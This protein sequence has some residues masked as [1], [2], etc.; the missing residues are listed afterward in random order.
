ML[1]HLCRVR[2]MSLVLDGITC[3]CC[4]KP[5]RNRGVCK[6]TYA[7]ARRMVRAGKVTWQELERR[8]VVLESR[9]GQHR[10]SAA[11]KRRQYLEM[12]CE[13]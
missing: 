3:P 5:A 4:G 10:Y 11:G 8:G 9:Q 13:Q 1:A 12:G 2:L 7:M 6:A